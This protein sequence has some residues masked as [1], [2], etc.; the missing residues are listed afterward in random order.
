MVPPIALDLDGD[1][2]VSFVGTD[3]GTT[4]DFGAGL[5]TTAWVA[6]NDGLLVRDGN[7]DGDGIGAGRLPLHGSATC[8][9]SEGGLRRRC[10]EDGSRPAPICVSR[11]L[12]S[13]AQ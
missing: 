9:V 12:P 11:F 8:T 6:G 5:V 7:G 3:A 1:G 2:K 4:F 10:R 13:C